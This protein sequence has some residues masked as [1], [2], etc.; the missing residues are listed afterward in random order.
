MILSLQQ[1][2]NRSIEAY[3]FFFPKKNILKS[4]PI[5]NYLLHLR[6]IKALEKRGG[7]HNTSSFC[8]QEVDFIVLSR[9]Y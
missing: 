1:N 9:E 8:L 5:A 7:V 4:L 6:Q 3:P 2:L